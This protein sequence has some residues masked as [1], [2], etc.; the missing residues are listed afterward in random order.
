MLAIYGDFPKKS[1]FKHPKHVPHQVKWARFRLE[2][3]DRLVG[4]IVPYSYD[5]KTHSTTNF[6]FDYNTFYVVFLDENHR[7]WLSGSEDR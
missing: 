1:D 4:F 2:S 7:F 3:A 5:G 6:K